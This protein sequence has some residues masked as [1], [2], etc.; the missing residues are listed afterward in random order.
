[1]KTRDQ[2]IY[3]AMAQV[4]F[5]RSEGRTIPAHLIDALEEQGW[6]LRPIG[7]SR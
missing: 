3:E 2:A 7:S 1:M 5:G 4:M 6:E